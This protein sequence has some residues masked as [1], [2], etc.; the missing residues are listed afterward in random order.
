MCE[1]LNVHEDML[2][3]NSVY[4]GDWSVFDEET[5]REAG[6]EITHFEQVEA[7]LPKPANS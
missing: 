6:F 2:Y 7:N 4:Y 3:Y 1:E 5:F